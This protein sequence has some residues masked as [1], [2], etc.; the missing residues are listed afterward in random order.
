LLAQSAFTCA[1]AA[2]TQRKVT[3]HVTKTTFTTVV[4]LLF[5]SHAGNA[6]DFVSYLSLSSITLPPRYQQVY[7]NLQALLPFDTP[8]ITRAAPIS[9]ALLILNDYGVIYNVSRHSLTG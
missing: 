4:K 7:Q 8:T 6:F 2:L 1:T 5:N 3:H 9:S